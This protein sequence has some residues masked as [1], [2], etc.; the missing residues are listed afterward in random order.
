MRFTAGRWQFAAA[1]LLLT[2]FL[3]ADSSTEQQPTDWIRKHAI[4]LRTVE[5]G[6]GF[7]DMQPL[8][9]VVGDARIVALGEATHGTR[10]F[11]QL[12]HRMLEFLASQKGFTIFSIEAN[13]P[14]AYRLNDFVLN[15]TG[16]PRQLLKGMYFWTWNT[17]EVLD[18][19]LWMREF[20]RS[21]KGK[22][23]FTGF[24][25]QKPDVAI[26]IVQSFVTLHDRSYEETVE[27]AYHD[28]AQQ[29][30]KSQS[31]PAFGVA[32]ATFPAKIAAGKHITYS[33]YIKT[34][35][36]TEGFA[37]LWWRGDGE[38][39]KVL[40]F[41][42]MQNRG[43][44][45]TTPWTRYEISLDVP[46]D[47]I[48][49]NFGVLHPGNGTAW[50]DSLEVQIDGKPFNDTNA[51][52][53][54]FESTVPRGFYTGGQGYEVKLDNSVAH[55]G[56]QSLRSSRL[57]GNSETQPAQE[58]SA[59]TLDAACRDVVEHLKQHESEFLR[60]GVAPDDLDWIIQNARIVLQYVQLQNGEQTRDKSMAENVE[61]I[62]EHNPGAKIVLW[63][64]NGHVKYSN[65][66]GF[67]PMGGYLHQKFGRA[68]VNFGFSFNEGS[69]RAIETGKGL[70]EFTVQPLAEGSLDRTL[71]SA[72]IPVFAL[73]L[74]ELPRNGPVARWFA[75][76]HR[77]RSIGAVYNE[78][79]PEAPMFV[80][81]EVWPRDFD[82]I[83]F[84]EMT[85]AS[86]GIN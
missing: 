68:L 25:M 21:G 33:G 11:F 73:D 63:A 56:K 22:L 45:G 35:G 80:S 55:T 7:D 62:A 34:E 82:V 30:K 14:E 74:R 84:V 46:S 59:R 75:A 51:F 29:K 57:S 40:A 85:T 2:L 31:Q 41:D 12:K 5:A 16:D 13:M 42:N 47:A 1:F 69:F 19:I 28:V 71:A 54:D 43:A 6:H 49:I 4:P 10:E 48:N 44:K 65:P 27:S 20:N 38:G 9:N 24:D 72:A 58:V 52:D 60:D 18:M 61:W 15:G 50:F 66:P 70:R 64:H 23:Q 17:D 39:G 36:I 26:Q 79:D 81:D 37:G 76:P 77:M 53:L 67:D 78:N 3:S 8:A 83:L 86:R 32:T